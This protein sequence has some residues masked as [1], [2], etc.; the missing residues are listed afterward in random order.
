MEYVTNTQTTINLT[1][2]YKRLAWIVTYS[3]PVVKVGSAQNQT[4]GY[5]KSS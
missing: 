2:H 5:E 1:P 3:D 4:I